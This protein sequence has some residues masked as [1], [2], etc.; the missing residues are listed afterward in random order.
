[1]GRYFLI[2]QDAVCGVNNSDEDDLMMVM[3]RVMRMLMMIL[4]N[5][6]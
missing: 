4:A 3:M 5:V 1:M 2:V 6:S